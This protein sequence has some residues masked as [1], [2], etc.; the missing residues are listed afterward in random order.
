MSHIAPLDRVSETDPP[1]VH[2]APGKEL[3]PSASGLTAPS[4]APPGSLVV[5]HKRLSDS[6]ASTEADIERLLRAV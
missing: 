5:S 6:E 1:L 2:I 3:V 4:Q